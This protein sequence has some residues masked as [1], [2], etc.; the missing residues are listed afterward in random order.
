MVKLTLRKQTILI[1]RVLLTLKAMFTHTD[2]PEP[3]RI[4]YLG[5]LWVVGA[6]AF[7]Y[8][9]LFPPIEDFQVDEFEVYEFIEEDMPDFS[10]MHDIA[11][12]KTR[13][14]NY[15]LPAIAYQNRII[16][17]KRNFL[18][19]VQASITKD[20]PISQKDKS[21]LARL[22]QEYRVNSGQ[23]A[24][25]VNSLLKRVDVIPAELVLMQAAN[26]SAWGT[27][28]FAKQGYNFFG[29]WC[30][31]KGCGFVPL[32]RNEGAE[33]EVAKFKNLQ[34]AVTTYFRNINRHQAYSKLRS[35]RYSLRQE[36]QHISAEALAHGLERY[37]ERGDEYIKELINMIRFN[38]KFL[39]L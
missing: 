13:F 29:L 5:C 2:F 6:I 27:S 8:P 30:F 12:K 38:R 28:R 11:E 31:K 33:H 21:K 20:I 9:F 15:L 26:E 17:E 24:T 35:I 32:R 1:M 37:S 14:F 16:I 19:E 10:S 39:S 23:L 7:S 36:N 34:H 18:F 22:A 4:I 25:T 3:S